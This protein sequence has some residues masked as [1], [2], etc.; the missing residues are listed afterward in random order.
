MR[1]VVFG[2][3]GSG[4]TTLARRLAEA[5]SLPFVELD[6]INWQPGWRGLNADAPEEFVRRVEAATA[7]PA[8]VC[9]GNYGQ[10]RAL[11]WSRATHLVWLD[12]QRRVIMFRVLRR[13]IARALDR[14]ELWPGTGNR[15]NWRHWL[16]PSHPIRWAWSTWR[17]RRA[18]AEVRL[19]DPRFAHL[20]VFRLRHPREAKA[21]S[22][23]LQS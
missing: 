23:Q 13:S 17:R 3:S 18:E 12:Y 4:K 1:I 11:L 5:L 10:V 6:R 7:G 14:R 22:R 8:W 15:E 21:V 9:D 19:R 20:V 16:H 2:T